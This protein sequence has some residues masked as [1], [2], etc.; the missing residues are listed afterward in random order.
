MPDA[1]DIFQKF[2]INL[3]GHL[4]FRTYL[5]KDELHCEGTDDS[6]VDYGPINSCG[7]VKSL[8][9]EYTIN[10]VYDVVPQ[11]S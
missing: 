11:G 2:T 6:S 7:K 8:N 5:G 3:R 4:I 1:I 9:D 10:V